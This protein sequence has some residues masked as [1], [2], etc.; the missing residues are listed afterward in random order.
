MGTVED[1]LFNFHN[2]QTPTHL[3]NMPTSYSS[4]TAYAMAMATIGLSSPLPNSNG[5]HRIRQSVPRRAEPGVVHFAN[6]H[7]KYKV[8]VP[9]DVVIA[10]ADSEVIASPGPSDSRYL[11]PVDIGGQILNLDFDTGSADL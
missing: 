11:C 5:G 10:L 1:V 7:R 6:V 2:C 4:L 9:G 8:N 3:S